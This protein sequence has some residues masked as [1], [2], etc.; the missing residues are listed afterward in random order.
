VL[1]VRICPSAQWLY[2]I[3]LIALGSLPASGQDSETVLFEE[4][5]VVEAATLHVQTLTRAPANVTVVTKEEIRRY[6]YRTLS[7]ALSNVRGFYVGSDGVLENVGVRGFALPGDYNTRFLVMLNGHALTDNVYN[8]MYLFG[9]D[10]GLDMDLVERIEVIRGPSSALYGSNGI[11]ATINIV[12]KS[13]VG[14]RRA[15][16]STEMGSLGD[17]KLTGS[18]SVYLGGSANLL[19]AG[20][21]FYSRGRSLS[22]AELGRTTDGVSAQRGYHTFA[23][24]I[25]GN[26]SAMAY[27]NERKALAPMGWY[28]SEFGD[29][30][31]GERD[32]RNFTE[33][34]WQ[35]EVGKSGRLQWRTYYDQFRYRG[36]YDYAAG[37][38]E[39]VD[40]RDSAEGDRVGTRLAYTLPAGGLVDL[41]L[42]GELNADLRNVQQTDN[43]APQYQPLMY[44]SKR[45]RAAALFAQQE[46][47]ISPRWTVYLGARYDVSRNFHNSLD[48]RVAAIYRASAQTTWKL[49]Y[50]RAFRNPSV[51]EMFYGGPD[52][53][54]TQNPGLRPE[55]GHT[56]EVV[57]ERNL[58][59]WADV[60]VCAYH[61]RLSGLIGAG[62]LDSGEVQYRN[63]SKM[64]SY[65]GELEARLHP[66]KR[67]ET[68]ASVNLMRMRDSGG[69]GMMNSPPQVAQWRIAAPVAG[70]R[71]RLSAAARWIGVRRDADGD[72]MA[73]VLLADATA[74]TKGL[75]PSFDLEFGARNLL[76]RRY[77]D[78]LSPEHL[79]RRFPE[80]GRTVFLRL[81]WQTAE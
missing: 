42:G 8:A 77:A 4:L 2:G 7:E 25:W 13:P 51:Y 59:R 63:Q 74:G 79:L 66:G 47:N 44:V 69:L 39:W 43:I 35:R 9:Q 32:S 16:V 54:Y 73:G 57:M 76:G 3:L 62:V 71:L 37:E 20:S 29:K 49:L 75:H 46:W 36:R 68:V 80:P 41:T 65:G 34:A 60:V 27:F 33:V 64:W 61:Y 1:D 38:G 14:E 48:P 6:G 26:W 78:P 21:G 28:L 10:F 58:G 45:E 70:D 72:R 17:A 30:G 24:L 5:P 12:T 15:R 52:T 40:Q 23:N 22:V 67:L 56:F 18:S 19:L 31:T 11:F 55:K 53:G 50:G 81:I